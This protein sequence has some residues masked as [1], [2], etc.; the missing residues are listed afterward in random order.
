MVDVMET[1]DFYKVWDQYWKLKK[2]QH[3][4]EMAMM[5]VKMTIIASF[6]IPDIPLALQWLEAL[7]A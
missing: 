3:T 7:V 6:C 1:V 4:E 2:A 5:Y